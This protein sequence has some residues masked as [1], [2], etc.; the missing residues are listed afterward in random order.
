MPEEVRGN[1][2]SLAVRVGACDDI[3]VVKYSRCYTCRDAVPSYGEWPIQNGR[4]LKTAVFEAPSKIRHSAL[5]GRH[6]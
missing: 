4:V 6:S 1:D 2:G 3:H 5:L